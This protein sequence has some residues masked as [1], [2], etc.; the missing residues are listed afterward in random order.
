MGDFEPSHFFHFFTGVLFLS[1]QLGK[2]AIFPFLILVFFAVFL[3]IFGIEMEVLEGLLLIFFEDL[4]EVIVVLSGEDVLVFLDEVFLLD[5]VVLGVLFGFSLLDA[6]LDLLSFLEELFLVGFVSEF[7]LLFLLA[8]L[9]WCELG[10]KLAHVNLW[11]VLL[12]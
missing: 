12:V 9:L 11:E 4:F 6:G 2:L 7:L 3:D 8:D 5:F 10:I 1:F